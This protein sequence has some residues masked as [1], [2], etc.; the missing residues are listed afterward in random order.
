LADSIITILALDPSTDITGIAIVSFDAKGCGEIRHLSGLQG[1]AKDRDSNKQRFA[2][3]AE[4]RGQLS[5]KVSSMAWAVDFVAYEIPPPPR[6][7]K[8]GLPPLGHLNYAALNQCLGAFMTLSGLRELPLIPVHIQ[9]C[10]AVY[11]NHRLAS[12]PNIDR[13]A[14]DTKRDLLKANAIAYVNA[15]FALDLGPTDDNLAD[16][17]IVA[18][19]AYR[20]WLRL[21]KA[22]AKAKAQKPLFG[23]GSG[24]PRKEKAVTV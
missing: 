11:G 14:R 15:T 6:S 20:N 1:T 17:V 18:C 10:K 24:T 7:S 8:P 5:A 12:A 19:G 9:T 13:A 21:E 16:A 22:A 3:I 4:M 2:R 23:K